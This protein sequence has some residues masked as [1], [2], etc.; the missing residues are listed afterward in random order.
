MHGLQTS[1]P[2]T[3][4][5]PMAWCPC[6][7]QQ[8]VDLFAARVRGGLL[9]QVQGQNGPSTMHEPALQG[10]HLPDEAPLLGAR[11][12]LL[13]ERPL[14]DASLLLEDVLEELL[15]EVVGCVVGAAR[16]QTARSAA[17]G[18]LGAQAARRQRGGSGG[19]SGDRS[20]NT[21]AMSGATGTFHFTSRCRR[22]KTLVYTSAGGQLLPCSRRR[23]AE[24]PAWSRAQRARHST[25]V[26][27]ISPAGK[28]GQ[29]SYYV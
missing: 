23:S 28:T 13:E 12:L 10:A 4:S 18:I 9:A 5:D 6:G 19:V 24:A 7:L 15:G 21:L 25:P 27:F 26:A 22:F 11:L 8:G 29:S 20:S 2:I 1:W 16:H 14:L 17:E 3:P